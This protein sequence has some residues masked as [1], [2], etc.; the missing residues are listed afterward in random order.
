MSLI[1]TMKTELR[2]LEQF[3]KKKHEDIEK[4]ILDS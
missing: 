1:E 3:I 4:I 2:R